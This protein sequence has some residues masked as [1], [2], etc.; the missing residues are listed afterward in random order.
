MVLTAVGS[1]KQLSEP[2]DLLL[3]P[4]CDA[5]VCDFYRHVGVSVVSA[6]SCCCD[7]D[8]D[9][10]FGLIRSLVRFSVITSGNVPLFRTM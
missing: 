9:G 6:L 1:C 2:C 10:V 4:V 3:L 5:G 7:D 8:D